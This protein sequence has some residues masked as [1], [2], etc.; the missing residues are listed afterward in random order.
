VCISA[1]VISDYTVLVLPLA[2]TALCIRRAPSL[3]I[4]T[5]CLV[6]WF[7][8]LS[9][10]SRRL[11]SPSPCPPLSL[12]EL[13]LLYSVATMPP[14]LFTATS[15]VP[16]TESYRAPHTQLPPQPGSGNAQGSPHSPTVLCE[17]TCNRRWHDGRV[18]A[19]IEASYSPTCAPCRFRP[20]RLAGLRSQ[21]LMATTPQC[22]CPL[23]PWH[24]PQGW[25]T[26]SKQAPPPLRLLLWSLTIKAQRTRFGAV[27]EQYCGKPCDLWAST[28]CGVMAGR[29]AKTQNVNGRMG[30]SKNN[31][32]IILI[33]A[34]LQF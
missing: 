10:I 23:V 29:Q 24:H 2:F 30:L 20:R 21:A 22:M 6:P 11:K 12:S 4:K 34:V 26:L 13:A 31:M 27:I 3:S 9:N 25:V 5:R 7:S 32:I 19:I 14:Q 18:T 28:V 17:K 15:P 33:Q 1:L 8:S 16:A